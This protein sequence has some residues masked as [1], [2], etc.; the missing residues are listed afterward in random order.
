MVVSVPREGSPGSKDEPVF[1]HSLTMLCARLWER[2]G[3]LT[4][5]CVMA[6]S[7]SS[8][9]DSDLTAK[10]AGSIPGRGT[11][12]LQVVW[13]GK[14]KKNQ[15]SWHQEPMRAHL[16]VSHL[17]HTGRVCVCV[18]VCV[19]LCVPEADGV[20]FLGSLKLQLL[21]GVRPVFRVFS[22]VGRQP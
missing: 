5:S 2:A 17:T 11:K 19:C 6:V 21:L 18:C 9:Q 15:V 16:G 4:E 14:K 7:W 20:P 13:Q 1:R 8:G 12:I 22:E 10:G 3:E